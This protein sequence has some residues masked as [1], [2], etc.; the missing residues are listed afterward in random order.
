LKI[1]I[2]DFFKNHHQK[3]F[4]I[5]DDEIELTVRDPATKKVLKALGGKPKIL[6]LRRVDN[7]TYIL[8]DSTWVPKT[9][10]VEVG[11]A[12][13]LFDHNIEQAGSNDPLIVL[14]DLVMKFGMTLKV[15]DQQN[16]FI[17]QSTFDVDPKISKVDVFKIVGEK[18]GKLYI[19]ALGFEYHK[20]GDTA[21]AQVSLAYA[22]DR[23]KYVGWLRENMADINPPQ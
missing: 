18:K 10:T 17:Y 11:L 23:E 13:R 7:G 9:Q 3:D 22:L 19:Y 14:Q 2:V 21:I 15:G 8:I 12:L 1:E 6:F 20:R 5:T 16:K 4:G